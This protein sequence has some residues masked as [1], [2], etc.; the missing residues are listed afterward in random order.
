MKCSKMITSALV[1]ALLVLGQT[2]ASRKEK[3][4]RHCDETFDYVIVGAG[5]TGCVLANRLSENGKYTVCVLEAGRDDARLPELLP[6]A[7]PANI[8]QPG[9][10]KWGK[11]TRGAF[12]LIGALFNRGFSRF[13]YFQKETEDPSSTSITYSRGC[14]WGGSSSHNATQYTRNAPYDWNMWAALGLDEWNGG[15][16]ANGF[17]DSPLVPFYR[18]VENRSQRIGRPPSNGTVPYYDPN[19]P[20]GSYGSFDD[21]DESCAGFDGMVPITL[22]KT[23]DEEGNLVIPPFWAAMQTVVGTDLAAFDYP[24]TAGT[25]DLVDLDYC[26]NAHLGGLGGRNNTQSDQTGNLALPGTA[27]ALGDFSNNVPFST[28][29]MPL[30]G[31]ERF[32]LPEEFANLNL[33]FPLNPN[34]IYP[35]QRASAANTYLYAAEGRPNLTIKSETLATGLIMCGNKATG[36]KYL[37]GWNIFQTGRNPDTANAGYGGTVGDARFNGIAAKAAGERKVFAR[38]AVILS[39]GLYNTPQLLMLSGIGDKSELAKFGIKCVKHLPGVGKHLIDNQEIFLYWQTPTSVN[40]AFELISLAAF[41]KPA[42][43]P[44]RLP[45]PTFDMLIGFNGAVNQDSLDPFIAKQWTELRNFPGTSDGEFG[46]N[47][48][49]NRL[50]DPNDPNANPPR[51]LVDSITPLFLTPFGFLVRFDFTE[52]AVTPASGGFTIEG[53]SNPNYNGKF[54][55]SQLIFPI[56]K[57]FVILSYPSDPG[58]PGVG[59]TTLL[60]DPAFIPIAVPLSKSIGMLVEKQELNLTEGF[61]RLQSADPTVPVEIFFDYLS[62]KDDMKS[63]IDIFKGTVFPMMLGLKSQGY[64]SGLLYPAPSDILKPGILD[65]NSLDDIDDERLEAFLKDKVGGHHGGGTCK[66]GLKND[67]MAVVGQ[68]GSVHGTKHLFVADASVF[69]VSLRWP[70]GTCYIIGEKISKD[71]L[72]KAKRCDKKEKRH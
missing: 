46:A 40:A 9:D 69:P 68:D 37:E 7:S 59:G 67:P 1:S 30:Y 42:G 72:K 45:F 62:N 8:P 52:Q 41:E 13:A 26:P 63:F 44:N 20:L 29:N 66:M 4:K 36:V 71:I 53:N 5:N 38:K 47:T 39:G 48:F 12:P 32:E 27:P 35:I 19:L 24:S 57:T 23:V 2:E 65:F 49:E 21:S 18:L 58:V 50:L 34:G 16:A 60:G 54:T 17:A 25:A 64:F 15:T 51:I 61:V 43:D 10:F 55:S 14:T 33:P 70:N 6:E 3:H 22:P 28:Y 56:T 11:Y 31:D